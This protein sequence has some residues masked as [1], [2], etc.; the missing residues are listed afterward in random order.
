MD[1]VVSNE[2]NA[3]KLISSLRNTGY[4]S[5]AAIEDII[6]NSV[7]A[8]AKIIKVFVEHKDKDLRV[9]VADNGIGMNKDVLDQALRL[10]SLTDK[11]EISDLGKYGMGLCTASI[12]MARKLEVISREKDGDYLYES[13]DLDEIIEHNKFIKTQRQATSIEK[14]MLMDNCGES[15]TIVTLSKV[16]RLSDTNVSQFSVKLSRDLGRIFRKFLVSGTSMFVNDKKVEAV[17]PLWLSDSKTRVYSDE[18]Y[19]LPISITGRAKEKIRIKIVL[20]PDM[21]DELMKE[22][23]IGPNS[24]GFY[25]LRNNREIADSQTLGVFGR[26]PTFNRMRIEL[27]FSASLDNEMGVRFSKDG[28]DPNQAIADFIK[29]EV[30]GQISSIRT[31]I[32]RSRKADP[33]TNID[34]S[35]SESVIAKKAKLLIVPEAK[36]E[37][38]APPSD[39]DNTE[40]KRVMS[41]RN[42]DRVPKKL[43]LSKKGM[44]VKFDTAS[45]GREGVLYEC[46][47]VGKI[48]NIR[49]NSDHPFYD[50]VVFPNRNTRDIVS[51]LDYLIFALASAELKVTNEDNFNV[52]MTLKSILSSNL[53]SL[54]S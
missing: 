14:K 37:R 3:A 35:D 26:H 28:V 52:L 50:Q 5:Y 54:L 13:Q 34:H 40:G 19:E 8:Q 47:Q 6:D 16:D 4:D 27:L 20:L 17:D 44:G 33:S 21:S 42:I 51:A 30:G 25:V 29:N 31:L 45:L 36:I 12:S 39:K 46:D 10:G 24:Q 43:Q 53:R 32:T 22:Y 1:Y 41:N 18:E 49:W 11:D 38:R 15:G 7:D 48:I 23:K 2:P 9:T